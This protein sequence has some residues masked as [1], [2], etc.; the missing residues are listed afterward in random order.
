MLFSNTSTAR[1]NVPLR[2]FA[3]HQRFRGEPLRELRRTYANEGRVEA[4]RERLVAAE[5]A[6][7]G[8]FRRIR[9]RKPHFAA[10]EEHD[11]GRPFG[12]L[13]DEG[14]ARRQVQREIRRPHRQVLDVVLFRRIERQTKE[15]ADVANARCRCDPPS[16]TRLGEIQAERDEPSFGAVLREGLDQQPLTAGWDVASDR[17]P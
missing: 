17:V 1:R 14:I 7:L 12:C 16:R 6:H 15:P 9:R 2:D 3:R 4:R 10:T 8:L 5:D 13:G 11:S